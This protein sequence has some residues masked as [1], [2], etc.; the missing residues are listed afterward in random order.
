MDNHYC[1]PP[2]PPRS[3]MVGLLFCLTIIVTSLFPSTIVCT[4]AGV[5]HFKLLLCPHKVLQM[6]SF[7]YLGC[8]IEVWRQYT[9][10][11]SSTILPGYSTGKV[12]ICVQILADGSYLRYYD[13]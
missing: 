9:Q 7:A 4:G 8:L 1:C 5:V 10:N 13:A 3:M 2:L 6:Y 11:L 12:V